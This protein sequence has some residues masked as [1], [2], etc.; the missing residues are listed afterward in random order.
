M[1]SRPPGASAWGI[2]VIKVALFFICLIPAAQLSYDAFHGLLSADPIEDI[3]HRTGDWTLRFLLITL[4]VTPIRHLTG[5]NKLMRFRRMLGLFSFFYA[6]LHFLT[7]VVLDQFFSWPDIV[8]DILE[9]NYILVGFLAFT[10]L[11]PLAITS[12]NGWV[13]RLGGKTWQKLHRFIYVSAI[14]G[15]T[16]FLWLV[17][18]DVTEP[19]IYLM[20]LTALLIFRIARR[21]QASTLKAGVW[22]T[23][24]K[25]WQ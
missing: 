12:T 21:A 8:E 5:I 2:R 15:V 6:C 11:I 4:A 3:T 25:R 9:R 14:L 22:S 1:K 7:Y 24:E 10:L 13:R 20:I 23:V 19:G 18:S 16:H 17:K